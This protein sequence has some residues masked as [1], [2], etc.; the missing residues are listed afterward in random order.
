MASLLRVV[1]DTNVFVSAA[2]SKNPT[3]PTREILE[4]WKGGE[5]L[6][7]ICTPLAEEIV[8]KLTEYKIDD[9]LIGELVETL[10]HLADWIDTPQEKIEA[11]LADPDDNVIIA[12]AVEGEAN[13]LVTYD[14]HFDVLNGE[15]RG[16]KIM[17]AI[18]FLENLRQTKK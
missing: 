7:L 11:L 16:V 3:S 17:K 8:E 12:C 14:P 10:A 2:L 5:F 13:Y 9:A 6:L 15:Y 1:L 18:P 4:R